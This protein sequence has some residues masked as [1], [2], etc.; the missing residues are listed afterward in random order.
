MNTTTMKKKMLNDFAPEFRS[1]VATLKKHGATIVSVSNGGP[2]IPYE[3]AEFESEALACDEAHLY[4]MLP[5]G[6][7]GS[8]YLVYGNSPGE[9]AADYSVHPVIEA[10]TDEHYQKWDGKPQPMI[11]SKY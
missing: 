4:V 11:E 10:A 7:K 5:D 2:R 1:L 6:K 9:I 3:S 8:L